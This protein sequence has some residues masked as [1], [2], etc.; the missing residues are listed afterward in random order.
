MLVI[1]AQNGSASHYVGP[2]I[3]YDSLGFETWA[4]LVVIII[5]GVWSI[6]N[7]MMGMAEAKLYS[8]TYRGYFRS[9][10]NYLDV[11]TLVLWVLSMSVSSVA[12][13]L[14]SKFEEDLLTAANS[15]SLNSDST[16]IEPDGEFSP[17]FRV[18]WDVRDASLN[19]RIF[20][21]I[22]SVLLFFQIVQATRFHVSIQSQSHFV[23]R[24]SL[25]LSLFDVY[26]LAAYTSDSGS[27]PRGGFC[28]SRRFHRPVH[29]VHVLLRVHHLSTVFIFLGVVWQR[30]R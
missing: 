12:I 15:Y 11:L 20:L 25:S 22:Y 1:S 19:V 29:A 21:N 16:S 8:G 23:A 30:F 27:L 13:S 5:Y 18:I 10:Y 6:F 7:E 24:L 14:M 28:S 4:C 17:V 9:V 26:R 2:P 3:D